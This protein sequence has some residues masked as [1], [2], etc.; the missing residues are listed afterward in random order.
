[1]EKQALITVFVRNHQMA[2]Q[3]INSLTSEA[4]CYR[5]MDKWTAGQ[6]LQH[7]LLTIMPFPKVLHSK[8]FIRDTFGLP[9]RAA[10]DPETVLHHYAQT[11]LKAPE[12][13]LPKGPVLY[14]ERTGIIA[15]IEQN[16][17]S[18]SALLNN[19]S[20]EELDSLVLP[21]PLLGKLSIREMF[22]LMSYHP[23]HHQQQI[24][25]I[26]ETELP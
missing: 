3:Y 11:S 19:Y 24:A 16:L 5:H 2:V 7:I 9:D 26:L 10:W 15:D 17:G 18:I 25:R 8:E 6:H 12:A 21:H 20:E 14:H 22:F 1:M 23:L 4:F 13:F